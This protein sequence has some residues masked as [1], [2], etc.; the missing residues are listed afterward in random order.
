MHAFGIYVPNVIHTPSGTLL[1]VFP[2]FSLYNLSHKSALFSFTHLFY[3]YPLLTITLPKKYLLTLAK[4]LSF[5]EN[6]NP[7]RY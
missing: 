3:P 4:Q 1:N 2:L 7:I 5:D 6:I